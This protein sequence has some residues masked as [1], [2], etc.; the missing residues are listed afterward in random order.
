MKNTNT[1]LA[2][3]LTVLV[4]LLCCMCIVVVAVGGWSFYN[5]RGTVR[6]STP[7]FPFVQTVPVTIDT[8]S[9]ITT[10]LPLETVTPSGATQ[11]PATTPAAQ[12]TPNQAAE[13]TLNTLS[14]ADVPTNDLNDLAA[15]LKGIKNIPGTETPPAAPYTTGAKQKFWVSNDETNKYFQVDATLQYVSPHLYF[16]VQDNVNFDKNAINQLGDTFE[17]KIYPKD[18]EFFGSEWTPG[19]DDDVHLYILVASGLGSGTAAYYSS[20]DEYDPLAQQY[21]NAHEMFVVNADNN[22]LRASYTFGAL[23]HEFQHMIHWYHDRN[24]ESWINEGLSEVAAFLNGYDVGSAPEEFMVDPDLQLNDWPYD[25]SN[26]DADRPHYG[27]SFL[28]LSYLLDR[29]GENATK[30]LVA[31]PLNGLVSVDDVLAKEGD[32]DLQ[33][34]KQITADD[35]FADWAV[36]N[37]ID[38]PSVGDGQYTYKSFS[39]APKAGDTETISRCPLDPQSREV[40]QYGTDYIRIDCS[41]DYTLN[42]SGSTTVGL[43]PVGAKSGSYAFWSNKG[44]ESDMTLTHAFDFTKQTGPITLKYATWYDIEKDYDY[45]YVEV[46]EDGGDW[47]IIHTPHGTDSNPV[48]SNYGWGYTGSSGGW[49]EEQADLSAYA[50]KKVEVRFEY[51]T[52][53][54]VY[55]EGFLLDDVSIPE[56]GYQTDFEK[57]DGGWQGAGF[58]RIENVLPQTYRVSLILKGN[59]TTVQTIE[60]STDQKASVPLHIGGDVNEAILVVS[61]TTRFTRQVANYEIGIQR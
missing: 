48:G 8:P 18:R 58:V 2:I 42:F 15:R 51:I 1:I 52:D 39:N 12:P 27:A 49:L 53:P 7:G 5:A 32:K 6:I 16:W 28:Y 45:A 41:G 60:L 19:I 17:K 35:V 43:I 14:K 47:K 34:G 59:T 25:P 3:V 22:D 55:G 50:G 23:A 30:D 31:D 9:P 36:T 26:P 61:G 40:H 54:N 21:S 24:E 44:N 4:G 57:D 38:D 37:Y 33:T 13:N 20:A 29:F 11:M 56:A 46:R 10:S